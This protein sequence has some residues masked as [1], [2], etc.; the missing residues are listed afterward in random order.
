LVLA[1]VLPAWAQD[2][3]NSVNERLAAG[4][5]LIVDGHAK[6]GFERLTLLMGQIDPVQESAIK[7]KSLRLTK[8]D[9]QACRLCHAAAPNSLEGW[10]NVGAPATSTW[11]TEWLPALG[12][13]QMIDW[14]KA[15]H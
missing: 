15:R 13:R 5:R 4:V 12:L 6:V 10:Y 7:S 3:S 9:T 8:A 11:A 14:I 2:A 1:H